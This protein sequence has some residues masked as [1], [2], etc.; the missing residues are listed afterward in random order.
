MNSNHFQF[1]KK[2]IL[3]IYFSIYLFKIV[4]YNWQ[5]TYLI[6]TWR[7]FFYFI[8]C[9]YKKIIHLNTY[10]KHPV[11]NLI[12]IYKKTSISMVLR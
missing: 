9:Q 7:D 3:G 6:R 10:E 12:I 4:P 1:S 8:P 11:D 5:A 2:C